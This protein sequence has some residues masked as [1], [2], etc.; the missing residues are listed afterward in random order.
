VLR[1]RNHSV[2]EKLGRRKPGGLEVWRRVFSSCFSYR[3]FFIRGIGSRPGS[4]IILYSIYGEF[5]WFL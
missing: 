5:Q 1:L 2:P 3:E 4:P